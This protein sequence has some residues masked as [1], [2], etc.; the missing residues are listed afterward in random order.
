M[1]TTTDT[2]GVIAVDIGGTSIQAALVR[3][4]GAVMYRHTIPTQKAAPSV[5]YE[6][7]AQLALDVRAQAE[8]SGEPV[9]KRVAVGSPGRF[10]P[11]GAGGLIIAPGTAPNLGPNR[12]DFDGANPEDLLAGFLPGMDVTVRNDG[13]TQMEYLLSY[14]LTQKEHAESL[15]NHKVAYL[16]PGTGLGAGFAAVDGDG[17]RTYHTDGHIFDLMLGESTEVAVTVDGLSCPVR[18]SGM[19]ED[20][21]SGRAMGEIMAGVDAMLRH[22]GRKAV[23]SP[24][25]EDVVAEPDG[26]YPLAA[27]VAQGGRMIDRLLAPERSGDRAAQAAREIVR[28]EGEMLGRILEKIYRGD[29]T[30]RDQSA[31]WPSSDT[32]WAAGTRTYVLGGGAMRSLLGKTIKEACLAYL[33]RTLPNTTFQL[34]VPELSSKDA[35]LLGAAS[36]AHRPPAPPTDAPSPLRRLWR[37][38]ARITGLVLNYFH[39]WHQARLARRDMGI[40]GIGVDTYIPLEN[41]SVND[42]DGRQA[43]LHRLAERMEAGGPYAREWAKNV[44][45]VAHLAVVKNEDLPAL[46]E[47][48]QS[49]REIG[50]KTPMRILLVPGENAPA[51]IAALEALAQTDGRVT[52]LNPTFKKGVIQIPSREFAAWARGK[53][54]LLWTVS[55]NPAVTDALQSDAETP[56]PALKQIL[57]LL[58][59]APPLEVV[60][61]QNAFAI[62]VALLKYA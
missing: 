12:T 45:T 5:F 46:G 34:L 38:I 54:A 41:F 23:F 50:A 30:K 13:V 24:L 15:K 59:F 53:G 17:G 27:Y 60:D 35:G 4:D 62:A 48:V 21:F 1:K 56:D 39:G 58:R 43:L 42:L 8:V 32:A 11:N 22:G 55:R 2:G 14:L 3:A 44:N 61:F 19:A 26:G 47:M 16:G 52:L 51:L 10:V 37:Y 25:L 33:S 6:R 20:V 57:N 9:S 40:L 49:L 36:L 29:I 18:L 31:Q 28:F 7:V